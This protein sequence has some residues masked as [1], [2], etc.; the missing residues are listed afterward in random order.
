MRRAF[1]AAVLAAV[2]M[3]GCA[4]HYLRY[5]HKEVKIYLR[6][7]GGKEVQFASSLD[8]YR[9]HA[10]RRVGPATWMVSLPSQ[11]EFTYFYLV[12]GRMYVPPCRFKQSDDFGSL[13]CV[14]MPSP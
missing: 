8:G 9:L 13:N 6:H 14:F 3:Q 2:F 12:D 4:S 10:A 11:A 7:R 5:T 1:I